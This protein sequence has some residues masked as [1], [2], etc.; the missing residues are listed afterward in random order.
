M[1]TINPTTEINGVTYDLLKETDKCLYVMLNGIPTVY[2][3]SGK[4]FVKG[5]GEVKKKNNR[6]HGGY[7]R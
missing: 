6:R 7:N 4:E 1:S 5:G 3:K 2:S